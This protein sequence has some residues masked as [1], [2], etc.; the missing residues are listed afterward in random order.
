V[1][2]K[3]IIALISVFIIICG[4][5]TTERINLDEIVNGGEFER[6]S[7][8][9][10]RE[11]YNN[12]SAG[13][14]VA[15]WTD[16]FRSDSY[17][18]S[19]AN[20]VVTKI[21]SQ[22]ITTVTFT[23]YEQ[24]ATLSNFELDATAEGAVTSV[25]STGV[26][27]YVNFSDLVNIIKSEHTFA[28]MSIIQFLEY[29]RTNNIITEIEFG[30][31]IETLILSGLTIEELSTTLI[32]DIG[33]IN[34]EL[35]FRTEDFITLTDQ[36]NLLIG[37]D[38]MRLSSITNVVELKQYNRIGVPYISITKNVDK[39]VSYYNQILNYTIHF[40]NTGDFTAHNVVIIDR[41]PEGLVYLNSNI[42]GTNGRVNQPRGFN[43]IVVWRIRGNLEPGKGGKIQI[44][45]RITG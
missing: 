40:S 19:F 11:F 1:Y 26:I 38:L 16:S 29:L 36:N 4:C 43:N 18:P 28:N 37:V 8:E 25:S 42:D 22:L 2:R 14:T 23:E 24:T 32:S 9:S 27:S 6:N 33:S 45:V 17:G 12:L 7:Y 39:E 15:Y 34:F 10:T 21:S 35:N 44:R 30:E 5:S 13:E 3:T 31:L 41:L 20:K